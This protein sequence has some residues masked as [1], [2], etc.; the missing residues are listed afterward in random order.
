MEPYQ[1][2]K[3]YLHIC[4]FLKTCKI[5]W[6]FFFSF[7]KRQIFKDSISQLLTPTQ[8]AEE[9]NTLNRFAHLFLKIPVLANINPREIH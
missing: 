6:S 4:N 7:L 5:F 9:S 1:K 3:S 8:L 2:R